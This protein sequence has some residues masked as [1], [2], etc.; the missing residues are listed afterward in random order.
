M[1]LNALKI[2]LK[3]SEALSYCSP[4]TNWHCAPTW[5]T[6]PWIPG[7]PADPT[8]MVARS[9]VRSPACIFNLS[10]FCVLITASMFS[11]YCARNHLNSREVRLLPSNASV[12]LLAR[13]CVW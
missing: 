6:H 4:I 9:A 11:R 2:L 13:N 7:V 5:V 8:V 1:F 10:P 12:R 3:Q